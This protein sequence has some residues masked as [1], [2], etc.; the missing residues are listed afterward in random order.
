MAKTK[1]AK[2]SKARFSLA[3]ALQLRF[4]LF[5]QT[6]NWS[7]GCSTASVLPTVD[8]FTTLNSSSALLHLGTTPSH[9]PVRQTAC[10]HM[11]A[12]LSAAP[13]AE[14]ARLRHSRTARQAYLDRSQSPR[15]TAVK[16]PDLRRFLLA[17]KSRAREMK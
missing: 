3:P 8:L 17:G 6:P 1:N 12:A 5:T 15:P 11:S 13:Q 10:H 14:E 4:T 7:N 9:Y 2:I 16:C